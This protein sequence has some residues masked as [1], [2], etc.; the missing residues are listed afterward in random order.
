MFDVVTNAAH[1]RCE[2]M[3][4]HLPERAVKDVKSNSDKTSDRKQVN[5]QKQIDEAVGLEGNAS[6]VTKKCAAGTSELG[7]GKCRRIYGMDQ[8]HQWCRNCQLV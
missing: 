7:L 4:S 6:E 1:Q 3:T 8:K 2:G 5:V